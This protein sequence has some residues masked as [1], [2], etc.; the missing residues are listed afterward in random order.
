M[1]SLVVA[2]VV[3]VRSPSLWALFQAGQS[4]WLVNVLAGGR[5]SV[6]SA[7]RNSSEKRARSFFVFAFVL[8]ASSSSLSRLLLM[9]PLRAGVRHLNG[10][11]LK[12][13]NSGSQ[14]R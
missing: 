1:V 10:R 8:V 4:E 9:L 11:D 14:R 2:V 5:E 6:G 13:L 3:G 12:P 7:S